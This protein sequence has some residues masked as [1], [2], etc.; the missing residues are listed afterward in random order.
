MQKTEAMEAI[1]VA[2]NMGKMH[3]A[4]LVLKAVEPTSKERQ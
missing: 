4:H 3:N 1:L 2:K